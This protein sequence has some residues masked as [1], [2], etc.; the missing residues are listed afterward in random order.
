MVFYIP[1]YSV[2]SL[3]WIWHYCKILPLSSVPFVQ[4]EV[5]WAKG[6]KGWND[7]KT[8]SI[9]QW[10]TCELVKGWP[11]I[12]YHQ[13]QF[14]ILYCTKYKNGHDDRGAWPRVGQIPFGLNTWYRRV[15]HQQEKNT[16]LQMQ[17]NKAECF[18]VFF[19][20]WISM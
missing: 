5:C 6:G 17:S 7:E 9:S 2:M 20:N 16:F 18:T 1:I 15:C 10:W 8:T 3:F 11:N 19:V 12:D 4:V 13:Y 14:H